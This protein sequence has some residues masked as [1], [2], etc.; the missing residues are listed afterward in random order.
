MLGGLPQETELASTTKKE[1]F[2]TQPSLGVLPR[3]KIPT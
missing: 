3:K 1:Q 2:R